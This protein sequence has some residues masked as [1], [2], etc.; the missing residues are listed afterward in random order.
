MLLSQG[1][2]WG[3]CSGVYPPP[4]VEVENALSWLQGQPRAEGT[5]P[6]GDPGDVADRALNWES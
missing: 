1:L 4:P 6:M 3:G 2:G 5:C